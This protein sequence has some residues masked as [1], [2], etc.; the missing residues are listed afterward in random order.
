MRI[1]IAVHHYPPQRIGGAELVAQRQAR[2]L[3]RQGVESRVVF[4]E[5]V[6]YGATRVTWQDDILDGVPVRRLNLQYPDATAALRAAFENA[7]LTAHFQE[8]ISE[9][10]PDI[11]HL[12]SGYLLGTAPLI[13][14][15]RCKVPSV[16]TLTDFWFLCPTIQLLKGDGTLCQGPEPLECARCLFDNRRV[17]RAIDQRAPGAARTILKAAS[18]NPILGER[19]GLPSLLEALE[20]RQ[21][22]LARILEDANVVLPVT[23]FLAEMFKQNGLSGRNFF[24]KPNGLE[25]ETFTPA[26]TREPTDEIVFGYMGQ[27]SPVK[28]ID[29]LLRAFALVQSANPGRKL[30]LRLYGKWN[31]EK[32]YRDRL[33]RMTHGNAAIVFAGG[34]QNT[35]ALELLG[36]MD[37]VVVPSIWYENAPLVVQE[38]FAART[39]VIGSDV[40]GIAELVKPEQNGL[41]FARGDAAALGKMMQRFVDEPELRNKLTG[42]PVTR[43]FQQD[44]DELMGIYRGIL[45]EAQE[46]AV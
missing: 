23:H 9:W 44:L 4:V 31:A 24:V 46:V 30:R 45:S 19:F 7:P 32:K 17:F 21:A 35:Q 42:F 34:Y 6:S 5:S 41:L 28:G 12:I 10:K 22:N 38:A 43:T 33:A 2:W 15:K 40:G 26:G 20:A 8:V 39:P 36:K 29:V 18:E 11:V 16:V 37:A 13:A 14:A 3:I 27:L 1:L 25:L